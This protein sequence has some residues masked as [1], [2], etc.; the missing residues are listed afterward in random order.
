MT[1]KPQSRA[2]QPVM[3]PVVIEGRVKQV[4]NCSGLLQSDRCLVPSDKAS[5]FLL[6]KLDKGEENNNNNRQTDRQI[7]T[8]TKRETDKLRQTEKHRERERE[9][10]LIHI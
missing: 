7:E 5:A 10:S 6:I 9:L 3:Q 2:T 1:A 8:G 4:K